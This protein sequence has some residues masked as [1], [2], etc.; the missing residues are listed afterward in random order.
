[1]TN[2]LFFE[3]KPEYSAFEAI[4]KEQNE[5]G[6]YS[7]PEQDLG[8][9]EQY[10]K[11]FY[12]KNKNVKHLVIIGI[13][14]SSLGL[15]AIYRTLKTTKKFTKKIHFLESTDPI[16]IKSELEKVELESA[17]FF[18]ISKSGTTIET[19]AIYKYILGLLS[20]QKIDEDYMFT[21]VTDKGSLLE[22]HSKSKKSF[23]L[24]IPKNVGGRFSVLS[25]VG[26]APL[27]LIE[28]DIKELLD[29]A[30]QIKNSFLK[31]GYLKDI[32]LKKA[33]YYAKNSMKYNINTLFVYS[34]SFKYFTEWYVQ[35]WGESLGKKQLNSSFNV[36]LTPVGIT[37]PKDQH[38]FL[39][40]IVDGFRDKSVTVLK[41]RNFNYDIKIPD[42]NLKELESLDSINKLSFNSLINLQADSVIEAL[43]D[44]GDIPVDTIELEC[45]DEENIGKFIFYY[46]LLT[47]LVANLIGVEAYGQPGVE[48][49]KI[50]LKNKL[51]KERSLYENY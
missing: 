51:S 41:I 21:Y 47:S 17:H 9:L 30:K 19:T 36:G 25:A 22:A 26:L 6:Y 46:E 39:Q 2:R 20:E 45:I 3:V 27:S 18:V 50:I 42:I 23:C 5:I 29:G 37:G 31:N 48:E 38:S 44:K 40:L 24:N 49:S 32:L 34:E 1:M 43:V 33:T 13:G 16:A 12:A 10:K 15:K 28:V 4:C 11:D 8:Y 7:L 35:L 14:G